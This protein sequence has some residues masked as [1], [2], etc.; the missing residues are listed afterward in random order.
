[1]RILSILPL[2][3]AT[4]CSLLPVKWEGI[5]FVQVPVESDFACDFK[6]DENYD[7]AA[8]PKDAGPVDTNWTIT[9]DVNES[10]SA[11]MVEIMK[12]K[13]G[14][15]FLVMG[16]RVFPATSTAKTFT[17]T[18]DGTTKDTHEE[19][20]DAGYD[21]TLDMD[22]N[23]TETISF[24]RGPGGVFSGSWSVS[25]DST[26]DYSETDQWKAAQ[27]GLNAGQ[28]PS[29]LWL[30]GR[31]P[32]NTAAGQECGSKCTLTLTTTCD[33]STD[34]TAMY[35]G[36]YN[37]GLFT[38]IG[39]AGQSPGAEVVTTGGQTGGTTYYGYTF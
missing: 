2:F 4:G 19:E 25:S 32:S 21:F 14:N 1:M 27:V 35:A 30:E 39:G 31:E 34:L 28:I 37:D 36:K 7:N 29:S 10:D 6:G 23:S 5:W 16:D 15:L 26:T 13:S 20:H 11:L 18:W 17:A 9:D 24:T 3:L 38:A 12:G 33:G 8:F 22:A